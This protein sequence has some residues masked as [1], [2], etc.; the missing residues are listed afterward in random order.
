MNNLSQLVVYL[1]DFPD[2]NPLVNVAEIE[3]SCTGANSGCLK[4]DA[5]PQQWRLLSAKVE[6]GGKIQQLPL[7]IIAK[8]SSAYSVPL[9]GIAPE[10]TL[11]KTIPP[12]D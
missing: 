10:S 5:N 4:I 6:M 3:W 8:R 1:Q 11:V 2:K 12:Q 9:H 7:L